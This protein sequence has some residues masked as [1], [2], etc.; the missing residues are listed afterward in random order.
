MRRVL[1]ALGVATALVVAGL[2]P[3]GA[4][5]EAGRWVAGGGPERTYTGPPIR[6]R[7]AG[8]LTRGGFI[9]FGARINQRTPNG[10]ATC[11]TA[12]FPANGFT[13]CTWESLDLGTGESFLP[14][15]GRGRVTQV[16]LR[17]GNATGPMRVVVL[18]ALRRASDNLYICCKAVRQTA[19]FT[20]GRN[21]ITTVGTNL[22]VFQSRSPNSAGFYVDEHLAL[23][24]LGGNIRIPANIDGTGTSMSGWYPRWMIG[25]ERTNPYGTSGAM[26]LLRARWRP[27]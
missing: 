19:T 22:S 12:T 27:A 20:P 1:L 18:Q 7:E 24:V 25:Q 5:A 21:G 15:I 11:R 26:I 6:A 23:S 14:P 3:A 4:N 10:T 13:S 16:R 9:E 8:P 17:V 2:A